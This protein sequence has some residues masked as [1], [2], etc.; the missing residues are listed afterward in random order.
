MR[1]LICRS[2]IMLVTFALAL[3]LLAQNSGGQLWVQAFEDRNGNAQ[4]D[5]NEPFLT[6]DVSVDLLDA[7]G[8]TVAS[9]TLDGA[10]YANLGY[11]GFLNL[12][13]GTYTV[14]IS[15]PSL[16]PTTP[17]HVDVTI[18]SNALPVTVLYGAQ[19]GANVEAAAASSSSSLLDSELARVALSGFAALVVIGVMAFLGVVIYALVLRRRYQ[20][21]M[22]RYTTGSM[23]A[24]RAD[25]TG[26]VRR[27]GTQSAARRYETAE[28]EDDEV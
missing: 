24:V 1:K 15:S 4:H 3:P 25:Q 21:E 8:V 9:G 27:T 26:E 19:R 22:V 5:A 10:P 13:P 14:V 11:V 28:P 18:T 16:T 17:D 12:D 23:R 7:G 20:A 2:L 6:R